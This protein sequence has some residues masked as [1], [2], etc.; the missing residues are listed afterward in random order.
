M[1]IV[2]LDPPLQS[3]L[4]PPGAVV[5]TVVLHATAGS[6][7]AGA[8]Q[9][10]R[11]R[12]LSYHYLIDRS[13]AITKCCPASC[14]AFHAGQSFGP[15]GRWCNAYSVGISFVNL[16]TGTDPY[17]RDQQRSAQALVDALKTQF[18][19]RWLT[20]HYWVSPGRKTDPKNYPVEKLAL[21]T[22]LKLWRP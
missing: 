10:L 14:R 16:N 9:T 1:V 20:T 12:G 15:Q 2:A 22:G 8:V 4:R 19:L 5:D 7:L 17:T 11:L 6:S 21:A 13:G 3:G 18:P